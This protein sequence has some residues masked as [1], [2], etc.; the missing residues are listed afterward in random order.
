[1]EQSNNI[2]LEVREL[3]MYFPVFKGIMHRVKIGENKAVDGISF[4]IKKR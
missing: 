3:K 4:H 2:L 1:M